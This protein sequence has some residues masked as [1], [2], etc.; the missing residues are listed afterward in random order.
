MEDFPFIVDQWRFTGE[1]STTLLII[2]H[3]KMNQK[4]PFIV[5]I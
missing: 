3:N 5:K 1:S 2:Y 4:L